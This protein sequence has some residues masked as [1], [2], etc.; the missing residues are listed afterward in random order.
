M[1]VI[2]IAYFMFEKFVSGCMYNNVQYSD[3]RS[4]MLVIVDF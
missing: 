3:V 4:M 2:H 1:R